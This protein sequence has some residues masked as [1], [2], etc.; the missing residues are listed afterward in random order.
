MQG[1]WTNHRRV[2][3]IN[4]NSTPPANSGTSTPVEDTVDSKNGDGTKS[5]SKEPE[6][7]AS[8]AKRKT[9]PVRTEDA[10]RTRLSG[11]SSS[12]AIAKDY[13][14]PSTRLSDLGGIGPCIEKMLE[15]VAMPLCHPEIYLHTGVQPPS[16]VLL[17]GPPGCGKTLLANA[18]AGEIGVP[19]ITVAAPTI[20]SGM[21]GESEKTLRDTFEEAKRVAPC[22]LFIDE[23][24]AITPK[25]ESA[26]REMERRIVAQFLTC[27]DDLSWDKTDNKPV[28]VIGATNR[29]D[30]LDAALRR[31]GRFDH[32]ISM[33][34]PDE[35]ARTQILQVLCAKLRLEGDFNFRSL[36]KATPGYVGADLAALTG[37][38]G[39]YAVKRIFQQLSDGTIVLPPT[40]PGVQEQE[41]QV[42]EPPTET[43]ISVVPTPISRFSQLSS[44]AP[45]SSI[46]NFLLAYP[47]PLTPSQLSPLSITYQDFQSAL[48]TIQPSSTREGFTTVPDVSWSDVGALHATR[49]EL[50]MAIV[51]PIRRPELFEKM[52]VKAS[53]GVLMWGPPGCGKTLIAKAVASE[54]RAN[55]ISVKGPELLNKYVGESERAV[56]QVF[57]R[58][59]ASAPCVIFFDELDALVPRR[60]DSLSESSARVVNTLLTEL[61][62][63]D[64]RKSVY[65]IG[66]TNRPDMI[67]PAMCRPG[68]LDKLLFVDLP[69]SDE[70]GEILRTIIRKVPLGT[71]ETLTLQQVESLVKTRCEGFSGADLAALVREAA[72]IALRSHLPDLTTSTATA[73]DEGE[74]GEIAVGVQHFEKALEKVGPSVSMLQRRRY[75]NLKN[76]LSN[77]GVPEKAVPPITEG[78]NGSLRDAL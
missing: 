13:T 55:F 61:D 7:T 36:A 50:H 28:I 72:V 5:I 40:T 37:A 38:A 62:G 19:F 67:D 39:V 43:A 57:T 75:E 14:P 3:K 11:P 66:A 69:S 6:G 16:G 10:K 29:P 9:R 26:Q 25:R 56:R 70:R 73:A 60:D 23:I 42:D 34:V 49:E 76:K 12:Q 68:R 24:D 8:P 47:N 32:E 31:A 30:S 21:S 22:L 27:M 41:M 33:N 78:A 35:E 46:S 48:P 65:V 2:A 17:H 64:A 15:L 44:I 59:R 51:Q 74:G 1:L 45:N 52:G 20:V 71:N 53:C 18:I 4:L 63:L 77:A 58:A 54:S